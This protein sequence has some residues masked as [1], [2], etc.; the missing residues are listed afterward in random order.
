MIFLRKPA[1]TYRADA[2][3]IGGLAA[4]G[5]RGYSLKLN[6]PFV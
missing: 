6:A 5:F 3:R 2:L 4:N 1:A